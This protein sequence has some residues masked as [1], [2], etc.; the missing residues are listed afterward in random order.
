MIVVGGCGGS[1][2]FKKGACH[3]IFNPFSRLEILSGRL[4]YLLLNF[5]IRL[6]GD[7]VQWVKQIR[8]QCSLAMNESMLHEWMPTV[9]HLFSYLVL[10]CLLKSFIIACRLGYPTPL[11]R[12]SSQGDK[13]HS[14]YIQPLILLFTFLCL[15]FSF[16]S[17][18]HLFFSILSQFLFSILSFL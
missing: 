7:R 15:W 3:K 9:V 6:G 5:I 1:K 14:S 13:H 16:F 17:Q 4:A 10:F 11:D 12:C 8:V 2:D 18:S